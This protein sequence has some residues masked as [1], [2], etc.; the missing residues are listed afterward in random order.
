MS[1]YHGA[2]TSQHKPEPTSR[3]HSVL[4]LSPITTG[5]R[6]AAPALESWPYSM[7]RSL[8][9]LARAWSRLLDLPLPGHDKLLAQRTCPALPGQTTTHV[10]TVRPTAG[11]GPK[12]SLPA[13]STRHSDTAETITAEVIA[14]SKQRPCHGYCAPTAARASDAGGCYY[15]SIGPG[16]PK[17]QT[18][19][20]RT[21]Q[22][23][24]V[25]SLS[26]ARTR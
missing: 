19:Q 6:H 5:A 7:R 12:I 20:N 2:R 26:R 22:D 1:R 13:H 24:T 15:D 8:D 17:D 23:Q 18:G 11:Q 10:E 4:L 25:N 21:Y 14:G 3:P 9:K 16:P